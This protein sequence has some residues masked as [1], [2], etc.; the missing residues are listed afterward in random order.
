MQSR[1]RGH[2]E[3]VPKTANDYLEAARSFLNRL[4][5]AGRGQINPLVSVE[6]AMYEG[7]QNVCVPD[8]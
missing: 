7:R 2:A 1:L 8:K 5:E 6:K 4:I 3:L